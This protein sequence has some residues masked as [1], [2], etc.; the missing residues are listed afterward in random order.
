MNRNFW[1]IIAGLVLALVLAVFISPFASPSPD[2]LERVAED[3]GFLEKAVD[4]G[5]NSPLPDYTTPG[6][7]NAGLSTGIAGG[8]GVIA[9]FGIGLGVAFILK[10]RKA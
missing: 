2:G 10:K 8:I 1:F 6:V 7:E 5:L 4:S 3:K 9:V